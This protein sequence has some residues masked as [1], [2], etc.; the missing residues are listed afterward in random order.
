MPAWRRHLPAGLFALALAALAVALARPERT[1]A[2]PLERASVMLV[3][4]VSG[5]MQA[6]DVEPSR[7]EAAQQAALDFLD[8][9]PD[10]VRVGAVAFSETPHTVDGPEGDRATVEELME[11]LTAVG[12]TATGDAL[13]QAL[14]LLGR[15]EGSRERPPAAI[16]L[17]SDGKT[18]TGRD[19]V[20][21]A[22]DARR[23][24]VP[25]YT[26][27]LGTPEGTIET[28]GGPLSVP[29]DPETMRQIARASGGRSFTASDAEGL[30]AVYERLGS[31][32]GT[33]AEEREITAGFAAGG[34]VLLLGAAGT[35]MRRFGRLP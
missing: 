14:E 22:R 1:V 25:V 8:R 18:T 33:R 17:L 6:E 24:K 31:Q 20:E 9:V 11:D 26:V 4:D 29:P 3:T 12:G 32:V 5:S 2:V 30:E 35:S 34:L 23:A 16:V 19:P 28:P 7:L 21:V 13:Q 15:R 10:E 27:A